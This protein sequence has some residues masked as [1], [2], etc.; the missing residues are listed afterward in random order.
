[1]ET[2]NNFF[3][4]A[5][6]DVVG[7]IPYAD[8]PVAPPLNDDIPLLSF[9]N[10]PVTHSEILDV[11]KSLQSKNSTDFNGLSASSL[12]KFLAKSQTP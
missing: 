4:T 11:I 2:L 12:S 10:S 3:I 9:T 6:S 8:P 5:A 7:N 1:V